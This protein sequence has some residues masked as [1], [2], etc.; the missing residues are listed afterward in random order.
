MHR[1]TQLPFQ[2]LE[3]SVDAL[4]LGDQLRGQLP[5]G[6]AGQVPRTHRS[7]QGRGLMPTQMTRR[8]TGD[9]LGQQPVYPVERF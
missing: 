3:P 1:L 6:T 5:A 9:Q 8:A 7:Q 2:L 4:E